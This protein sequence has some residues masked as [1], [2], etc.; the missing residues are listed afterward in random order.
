M[1]FGLRIE[2]DGDASCVASKGA[3]KKTTRNAPVAAARSKPEQ[4][5][6]LAIDSAEFEQANL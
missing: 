6:K 4:I 3:K 5:P 1:I 2:L